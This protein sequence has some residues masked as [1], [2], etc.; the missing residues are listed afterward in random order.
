MDTQGQP[1]NQ[2]E[3]PEI[4]ICNSGMVNK[5]I[6]YEM[7]STCHFF[8]YKKIIFL[9]GTGIQLLL[10]CAAERREELI[11]DCAHMCSGSRNRQKEP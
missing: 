8:K 1:G 7:S 11:P 2:R 6:V 5:G 3:E 9:E 4:S 10:S